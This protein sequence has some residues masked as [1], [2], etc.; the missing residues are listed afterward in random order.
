MAQKFRE[1]CFRE[2]GNMNLIGFDYNSAFINSKLNLD[3]GKYCEKCAPGYTN[4]TA[5][6]IGINGTNKSTTII[7]TISTL[8]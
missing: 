8:I 6:C 2:I 7:K 5:G 4:L 1:I 3:N